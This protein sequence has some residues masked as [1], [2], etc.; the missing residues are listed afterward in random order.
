MAK[1]LSMLFASF[2]IA[3]TILALIY[4]VYRVRRST[5]P[6]PPG[7]KVASMPIYDNWVEYRNWG[8]EYGELVYLYDQNILVL[9]NSRVAI[10]LLEHRS[11]IYSDRKMTPFMK[12]CG[13]ELNLASVPCSDNWRRKRKLFQQSFRQ[14]T[15][16]RFY[17]DQYD[18]VYEFLR[19][20]IN[21]PD[22]FMRHTM[23][24]SQRL[25]FSTLWGLDVNPEDPLAQNAVELI[26]TLARIT[27]PGAFPVMERFP[28]LRFMPS[29]LP[30][31]G[32]KRSANQCLKQMKEADTVPFDM[33]VNN[34]KTGKGTSLVA[35]LAA[36]FEGNVEENE[37]IK[38]IG[39]TSY[40]AA[41]DT[42]SI[43]P[44]ASS[45]SSFILAMVLH[46][47]VQAKGQEEIDRVLGSDR[48]P[49]FGDRQSLPYVEAIYREVMRL[50][51]PFP[52]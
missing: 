52:L 37:A 24:L 39:T 8:R 35:E 38:A 46:R 20:L 23:A 45:I 33:A 31:C 42:A 27:A 2:G 1:L 29:W 50:H 12:L 44:T 6:Y 49:T 47:D 3:A 26:R 11:R 21:T 7:P 17:P 4:F 36:E 28:W 34:S 40:L 18:K 22:Q 19:H 30:G 25:I 16:D 15:I 32:F 41:A 13:L 9:N 51:P 14:S 43:Y 10:D 48:L 5:L